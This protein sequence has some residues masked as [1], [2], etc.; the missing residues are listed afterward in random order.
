MLPV[1][2]HRLGEAIARP[3]R[4]ELPPTRSRMTFSGAVLAASATPSNACTC[5]HASPHEELTLDLDLDLEIAIGLRPA[6]RT[7]LLCPHTYT[8]APVAENGATPR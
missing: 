7:L 4:P 3:V 1:Q 5:L 2:P 6:P 8:V